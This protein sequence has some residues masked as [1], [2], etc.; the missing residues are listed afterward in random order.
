MS[1]PGPGPTKDEKA[2]V[3]ASKGAG[4]GGEAKADAGEGSKTAQ[5]ARGVTK[6]MGVDAAAAAKAPGGAVDKET[7]PYPGLNGLDVPRASAL[8]RAAAHVVSQIPDAL[9]KAMRA[10]DSEVAL[11]AL[12]Q[13]ESLAQRGSDTLD[14]LNAAIPEGTGAVMRSLK[15]AADVPPPLVS[16]LN[17]LKAA[18]QNMATSV[19][20]EPVRKF[21]FM[22]T[23]M[24][25]GGDR[26]DTMK[27]INA[28]VGIAMSAFNNK[29][30]A[31]D[32]TVGDVRGALQRLQDRDFATQVFARRAA[33][34]A[35]RKAKADEEEKTPSKEKVAEAAK[36][37]QAK[38]PK[39]MA[40][41]AAKDSG[42]KDNAKP[43]KEE[44]LA[45]VESHGGL[46]AGTD[47]G[48]VFSFSPKMKSKNVASIT[49]IYSKNKVLQNPEIFTNIW[50]ASLEA[51][52]DPS[53]ATRKRI[54]NAVKK[55]L[56]GHNYDEAKVNE[57]INTLMFDLKSSL[58]H[59]R[60]GGGAH[61]SP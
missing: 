54:E 36:E 17:A 50:V 30:S 14:R 29:L 59:A 38:E 27:T 7:N 1:G 13:A 53:N 32:G 43:A 48:P 46:M 57:A 15:S 2:G 39:E 21:G 58:E 49:F 12:G 40:P 60:D 51:L 5:I 18:A 23:A 52:K 8:A 33:K 56:K 24:F 31:M 34:E 37:T 20:N 11:G 9:R 61:R 26:A 10:E 41:A 4:G 22:E 55:E 19:I 25:L 44:S 42:P 6:D 35:A 45:G 16:A 28:R 47:I 3:G